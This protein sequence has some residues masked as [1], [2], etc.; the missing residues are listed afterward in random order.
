MVA[1]TPVGPQLGRGK[2]RQKRKR[3]RRNLWSELR[4]QANE[5]APK[6]DESRLGTEYRVV[7]HI[8]NWPAPL[9]A[10][11]P[12]NRKKPPKYVV[13]TIDRIGFLCHTESLSWMMGAPLAICSPGAVG[14]IFPEWCPIFCAGR[15]G[16][17][18][19]RAIVGSPMRLM[20]PLL[21]AGFGRR[22]QGVSGILGRC[23]QTQK[24]HER[25]GPD[26][27]TA[28]S[29]CVVIRKAA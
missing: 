27:S 8:G 2:V 15:A 1:R 23:R 10:I 17:V 7:R 18:L 3:V 16:S 5:R 13:S 24:I 20:H 22:V 4:T 25:A 29:R 12:R 9:A 11:L 21:S 14:S 28:S 19:T 6:R 26:G